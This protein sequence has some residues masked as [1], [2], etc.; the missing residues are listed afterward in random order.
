MPCCVALLALMAPRIAIILVVIF[1]DYIGTAYE[2]RLVPFLGFFFLYNIVDAG[3]RAAFYNQALAGKDPAIEM[4]S[5][6]TLPSPGGSVAGG[7]ELVVIGFVL[8]SNTMLGIP[9]FWL[10]EWWPVAPIVFGVYLVFRGMREKSERE[11]ER[12]R[13]KED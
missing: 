7:V 1:S 3:R 10:E 2:T 9:W 6:L 12:K 11:A 4:P 8:L 5:D 13:K